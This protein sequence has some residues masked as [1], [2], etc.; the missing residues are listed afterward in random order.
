MVEFFADPPG[1]VVWVGLSIFILAVVVP[2]VSAFRQWGHAR[3]IEDVPTSKIRSA[4]QGYIELEGNGRHL[5]D[6]PL[7]SPL[8]GKACLWYRFK[9]ERR[10]AD[11]VDNDWH[12]VRNGCSDDLFCLEDDTGQCVVDPCGA[13]VNGVD[14]LTWYGDSEHPVDVPLL[15]SGRVGSTRGRYRY[16]ESF[17][18]EKQPLYVIGEFRTQSAVSGCSVAEMTRDII[19]QWKQDPD[20][21]RAGFDVNKDGELD[22]RE[23]AR[24]RKEARRQAEQAFAERA[25]QP[26]VH[27]ISKSVNRH[28]PFV[29]SPRPQR[30]LAQH[31]RR[32]ALIALVSFFVLGGVVTWMLT[33]VLDLG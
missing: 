3:M 4:H 6:Q 2:L 32:R 23:W 25:R 10:A 17:I 33:M 9:V 19:R 15:G 29:I 27:L 1:L 8:T 31:Y 7:V 24:V 21:L 16:S 20:H 18:L 11:H 28:Y 13:D 5:G 14:T 26:D 22:A 12:T 30:H